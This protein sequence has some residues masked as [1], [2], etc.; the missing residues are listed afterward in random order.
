[1]KRLR[2]RSVLLLGLL[3]VLSLGLLSGC[4]QKGNPIPEG[5]DEE[6]ILSEGR[7]VVELLVAGDYQTV[8]DQMRA[9]A[10]EGVTVDTLKA[11][12]ETSAKA[13]AYVE[14]TEAMVTGRTVK[15]T[16][17]AYAEA[18]IIA[19]HE[20]KNVRYRIGFDTNMALI[21]LEVRKV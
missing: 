21:G 20:K 16:G 4:T 13:G 7:K 5:M 15:S 11:H 6:L 18:V 9:D 2:K 19:K 10:A 8:V 14:E 12:M 17:E 1:M 3:L